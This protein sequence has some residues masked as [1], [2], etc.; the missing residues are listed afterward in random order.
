[1][2]VTAREVV[3]QLRAQKRSG[4][5]VVVPRVRG[6]GML[7]FMDPQRGIRRFVHPSQVSA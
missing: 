2:M 7:G 4:A 3:N 6:D 5:E 1:M